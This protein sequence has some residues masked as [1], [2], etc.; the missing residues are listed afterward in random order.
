MFGQ[1]FQLNEYNNSENHVYGR[2]GTN[3]IRK[4]VYSIFST[5]LAAL[6]YDDI[7]LA[8]ENSRTFR[9]LLTLQ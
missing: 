2:S 5:Q 3:Y 6:E 1:S 9:E 4:H 7:S 8:S